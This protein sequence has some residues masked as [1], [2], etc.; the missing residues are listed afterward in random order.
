MHDTSTRNTLKANENSTFAA[1]RSIRILHVVAGMN[2]GG[3]ETWLMDILRR[4]DRDRFQIDFL[5]HTTQPCA[6][7]EEIRALNSQIIPCLHPSQPWAYASNFKRIL[8]EYGPYDI[9]HSHVY[10]FSGYVLRLAQQAGVPIRIAHIHTDISSI[11]AKAG[12]YR[13]VYHTLMK[14]LINRHATVGLGMSRKAVANLFGSVSQTDPRSQVIYYGIDKTPFQ[15]FID[16]PA[17]RAEFGIPADAFVIGHVGRFVKVKNHTF[18]LDIAAEVAQREPKM[19]LLLVGDGPLRPEI[20]HK[21]AQMGLADRIIFAGVRSD[22][23]RLMKGAM[24]VFLFPSLYEGL[25]NVRLEAQAAG[26]PCVVSDT[27]PNEAD[28]V[29]PLVQRLSLSQP[30]YAWAQALL[31]IKKAE[32]G[33]TPAEALMAIAQSPFNI[34]NSVLSLEKIY[35]NNWSKSFSSESEQRTQDV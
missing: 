28:V 19:R 24:D 13:R 6:Y 27:V 23:P 11:E 17:V 2:R 12:L 10:L 18:I 14:W 4:T 30:A 31:T 15:N 21:A 35:L 26:L 1:E 5:V 25:G 3:I 8:R 9:V 32:L 29:K 7:D 33:I 20:E 22:I 34:Q 16:S